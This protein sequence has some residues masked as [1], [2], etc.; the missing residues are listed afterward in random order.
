MVADAGIEVAA[1]AVEPVARAMAPAVASQ[2]MSVAWVLIPIVAL[3]LVFLVAL[4]R[5]LPWVEK[6]K[7]Q[8]PWNCD[9]CLTFWSAG[10]LSVYVVAGLQQSITWAVIHLLPGA[11]LAVLLL[12]LR[13]Y[14][15][16]NLGPPPA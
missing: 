11:G 13:S 16:G 14:W 7:T 9:T 8:K 3:A 5:S 15:K 2:Q 12:A 10:A 1:K 4:V 6:L